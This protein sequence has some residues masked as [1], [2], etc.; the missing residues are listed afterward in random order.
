MAVALKCDRCGKLYELYKV[1][2]SN[3]DFN[4][5]ATIEILNSRNYQSKDVLDLCS[6]CRDS[7]D[8]WLDLPGI[9]K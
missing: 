6:E 7:L 3:K 2:G 9:V 5:V 1:K 8:E 4:G